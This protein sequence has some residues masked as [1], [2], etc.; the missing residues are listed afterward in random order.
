M[1]PLFVLENLGKF[2]E[3]VQSGLIQP[4]VDPVGYMLQQGFIEYLD[5]AE[6]YCGVCLTADSL[7]TAIKTNMSQSHMTIHGSFTLSVLVAK[8]YS[9]FNQGPRRMYT[10][11]MEKRSISMKL[12]VD[13]G[14][15]A[16][17]TLW[18]AQ[19]PLQSDPVDRVL[20]LRD[21]E[22]NGVNIRVAVMSMG[23]NMEDAWT[24]KKEALDRG[25]G[26]SSEMHVITTA[27]GQNCSFG[28][29]GDKCKGRAGGDKYSHLKED[30]T[31]I[32]GSF[33][34]GGSAVV[35]KTF[36]YK[37][38]GVL[39]RRCV[40]KFIPWNV[41]YTVHSVDVY[42]KGKNVKVRII[43]VTMMKT[44]HPVVGDKFYLAHGQ[45]GTCGQIVSGVDLPFIA[46]G[47]DAGCTPTLIINVCSLMRITQG[48]L[49][50]MMTSKARALSPDLLEQY[51]TIFL[52]KISFEQRMEVATHILKLQ[53]ME[54]K[55]RDRMI[56]GKTGKPLKCRIFNGSAYLRVLKHMAKDKLRSRARGPTNELT[57][58]TT[59]GKKN[60]GGQKAGE[61]E[62]WNFRGHGMP[63]MFQN[64]NYESADKFMIFSCTRCHT[65]AIGCLESNFYFCKVCEKSDAI[66]RLNIPYITCLTFQELYTAGWGH[67]LVARKKKYLDTVVDEEAIFHGTK[68]KKK[69]LK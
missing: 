6:E 59:V 43:R 33:L 37:H 62:N 27:L 16:S 28:K 22:P 49:I 38:D 36:Q 7:A 20:G 4:M 17:Y 66:V 67:T 21:K 45:K 19:V 46:S 18:N 69:I 68:N 9:T 47:P 10:G 64:V 54:Y 60:F 53:G 42:P 61:M 48:L 50:E 41:S 23:L 13:R 3:C 58:Q 35:G 44:N 25:L 12:A 39:E 52:S 57:R 26:I 63:F 65:P 5:A 29:P 40:S 51:N 31:P 2:V 8:P 56:C 24:I 30:G 15:T 1:R 32:L 11:N 14:T 34:H 55:G